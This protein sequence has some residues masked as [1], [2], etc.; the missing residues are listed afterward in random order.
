MSTTANSHRFHA[1]R[2]PISSP[3]PS[4]RPL[5]QAA[6]ERHQPAEVDDDRRLRQIEEQDRSE[7]EHHLRVPELRRRADPAHADDE[8]DLLQHEIAQPELFLERRAPLLDRRSSGR[9]RRRLVRLRAAEVVGR[10]GSWTRRLRRAPLLHDARGLDV[11]ELRPTAL[12]DTRCPMRRSSPATDLPARAA[13]RCAA[14]V[15]VPASSSESITGIPDT[16]S[17]IGGNPNPLSV[18]SFGLSLRLKNNWT[19]RVAVSPR[20]NEI[21]P[22]AFVCLTGSSSMRRVRQALST[23]GSPERP[24]CATY[25]LITRKKRAR[26]VLLAHQLRESADA[27]RRP[28][29]FRAITSPAAAART[30]RRNCRAP[31]RQ[32]CRHAAGIRRRR[33][34]T[35]TRRSPRPVAHGASSTHS[36]MAAE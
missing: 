36:I 31:W 23:F 5:I 9:A 1:T 6:L 18:S 22:R 25:P 19:E 3:S 21:V 35:S 8:H 12:R 15:A 11:V 29:S 17:A 28:R 30:R 4:L 14:R 16:T 32:R 34:S 20:A 7:P 27:E 13:I 2:T 24:N 33:T 26:R 10:L